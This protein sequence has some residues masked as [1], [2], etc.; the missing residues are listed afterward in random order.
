MCQS[1]A[2]DVDKGL[3]R[4]RYLDVPQLLKHALGLATQLGD[5]FMLYYAY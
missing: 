2:I 3:E 4:F 1:L 5:R